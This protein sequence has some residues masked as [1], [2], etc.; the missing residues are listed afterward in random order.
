MSSTRSSSDA[1]P[2]QVNVIA[3][4]TIVEGTI[5]AAGDVR[6]SGRLV[7]KL[8]TD[9]SVHRAAI[10][11]QIKEASRYDAEDVGLDEIR[12]VLVS[13][14]SG[15]DSPAGKAGIRPGDVIIGV[16]GKR[17]DRV[18]QLQ[19]EIGFRKP[20]ETVNIEVAREGGERRTFR[21]ELESLSAENPDP[22]PEEEEAEA[23]AV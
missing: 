23:D 11:V 13:G 15:E 19:Q 12:G 4:G 9:G 22:A 17:I 21:V 2:G 14:F 6:V 1:A 10:G 5:K 7:G 18:G 3:E 20:G 16:D 8:I